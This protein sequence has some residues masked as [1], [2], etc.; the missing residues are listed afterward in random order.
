MKVFVTGATGF[1]GKHLVKRLVREGH[2][3]VCLVRQSSRSEFLRTLGVER[4]FG[5][6]NDRG[7][8]LSGMAGCDWLFHLAN[9]YSMWEPDRSRFQRVNVEGTRLVMESALAC[10]VAKVVYVSTVA[11][12]GKPARAPFFEEDAPG[13]ELFSDYAR[14]KA[15]A[16]QIAWQ[17]YHDQG[18][19]I[20]VLYPGIVLGAGDDKASGHYIQDIIRKRVPS[21][22]FHHSWATYVYVEDVVDALLSAAQNPAGTGQKY[23]IGRHSLDGRAYAR[24]ISEV[25]G[26][27]LP[28]FR[29]PDWLVMAAAYLL[30]GVSAVTRRPPL[31]GLSI[32]AGHTLKNGFL[33]DGSKAERELGVHY[34]DIRT[35]LAEAI[36]SYREQWKR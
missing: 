20:T 18:L 31:W 4:V 34:T 32:D 35:A 36:E 3:V 30:T 23:L 33:C 2:Q 8:L 7:A 13:P 14:T 26:V 12:Y 21:T 19:P 6:V 10:R 27:A 28:L 15:A 16:D 5:D 22:I 25:S 9:L 29:F 17:L 1:I 11:V 24:L